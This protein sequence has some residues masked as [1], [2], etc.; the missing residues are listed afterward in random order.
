LKNRSPM[1]RFLLSW[2]GVFPLVGRIPIGWAYSHWLGVFPLVGRIPIGWAYS[3]WLG[4]LKNSAPDQPSVA[5]YRHFLRFSDF[6]ARESRVSFQGRASDFQGF[7]SKVP[8]LSPTPA[9]QTHRRSTEIFPKT[10]DS[11]KRTMNGSITENRISY[12]N[13]NLLLYRVQM[14]LSPTIFNRILDV[15]LHWVSPSPRSGRPPPPS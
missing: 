13:Y 2:L 6:Q 11:R 4:D 5:A 14:P 8:L 10:P 12:L 7:G 15:M 3:H 1:T 9:H